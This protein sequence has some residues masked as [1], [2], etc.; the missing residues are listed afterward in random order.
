LVQPCAANIVAKCNIE[1]PEAD[2]SVTA[3][4]YACDCKP[5]A[6]SARTNEVIALTTNCDMDH[7]GPMRLSPN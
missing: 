5:F 1:L 7:G 4:T 2:E 6:F 3:V